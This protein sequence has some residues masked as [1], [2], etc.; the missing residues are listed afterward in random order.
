MKFG[1]LIAFS[2]VVSALAGC[3]AG[4]PF[5]DPFESNTQRINAITLS[6][7]NAHEAN[8]AIQV[9]DPWPRYVYDTRIPGDGQRLTDAVDRYEDVGKLS[10]A[11]R[12][13]AP[14]Y[15]GT[16]GISAGNGAGGQ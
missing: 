7:G 12:P 10:K 9:I 5:D 8:A 6:A 1:H 4:P 14:I 16:V 2:I 3:S 11:P 15:S 13:I